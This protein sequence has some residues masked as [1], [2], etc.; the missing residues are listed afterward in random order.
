[1]S[2]KWRLMKHGMPAG[3]VK[4]YGNVIQGHIYVV[5]PENCD[6]AERNFRV[7]AQPRNFC[8]GAQLSRNFASFWT[9]LALII[10][11]LWKCLGQIRTLSAHNLSFPKFLAVCPKIATSCLLTFSLSMPVGC[12]GYTNDIA[13]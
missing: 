11:H 9:V 7:F 3:H 4:H 12:S 5:L 10:F 8:H 13:T 6:V 2:F 1:M